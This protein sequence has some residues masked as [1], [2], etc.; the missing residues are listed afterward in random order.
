MASKKRDKQKPCDEGKIRLI[1][2]A[3]EEA[4]TE[5]DDEELRSFDECD[6]EKQRRKSRRM[7]DEVRAPIIAAIQIRENA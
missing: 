7:P 3:E 2:E 4:G 6:Y 5:V 1:A